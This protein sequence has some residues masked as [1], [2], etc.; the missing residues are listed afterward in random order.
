[1]L[2][3]ACLNKT[4]SETHKGF[5][6][7]KTMTLKMF[8]SLPQT[9]AVNRL[10]EIGAENLRNLLHILKWNLQHDIRFYRMTVP[11]PL[12]DLVHPTSYPKWS[13]LQ[14]QA[15]EIGAF[16]RQHNMRVS[17][18]PDLICLGS[19]NDSAVQFA[20][21]ELELH[22]WWMDC[23]ALDR[24]VFCKINIHVGGSYGDFVSTGKRF[25]AQYQT[26]SE[27][28][29]KRL[30][31]ENDDRVNGWS[32]GLLWQHICQHTNIPIVF[33][34]HHYDVGAKSGC[35]ENDFQMAAISWPTNIRPIVHHSESRNDGSRVQ[36]HSDRYTKPFM[37]PCN[38]PVDIM[39]ECKHKEQALLEYRRLFGE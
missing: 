26:L 7:G 6:P 33:D 2:G 24:S 27:S 21:T 28:V 5:T 14:A 1:M 12:W 38:I 36:A 37:N 15:E 8:K 18:H 32:V 22:A 31:L 16:I 29:R 19:P 17:M 30:T 13:A 11:F 35:Y 20:R 3:Y 25:V 9:T 4:L 34:S 39:L 10:Q 23:L